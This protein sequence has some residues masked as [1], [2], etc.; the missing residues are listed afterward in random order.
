[1]QV[2]EL[3]NSLKLI[4]EI[5]RKDPRY[6]TLIHSV[7]YQDTTW[8][9]T[10]TRLLTGAVSQ[11]HS[12]PRFKLSTGVE[13]RDEVYDIGDTSG[14]STLLLPSLNAGYIWADDI[15]NTKHGLSTSVNFLGAYKGFISWR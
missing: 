2:A 7:G 12:G 1:M 9:D 5:P 11:E 15:L 3:E 10:N 4:Y 8:D 6:D 14:D 13:V